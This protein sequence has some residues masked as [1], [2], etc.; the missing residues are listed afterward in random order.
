MESKIGNLKSKNGR[1]VKAERVTPFP[2]S[3]EVDNT[4]FVILL[5]VHCYFGSFR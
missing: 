5:N 3:S 2:H 4:C 1:E